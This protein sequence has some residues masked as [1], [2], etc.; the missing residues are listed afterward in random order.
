MPNDPN[1]VAWAGWH[2]PNGLATYVS[3]NTGKVMGIL[4]NNP[5]LNGLFTG[6]S[7]LAIVNMDDLLNPALIARDP[8]PSNGHKADGSVDLVGSG[9]VRFVKVQ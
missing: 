4:M 3:P 2:Q 5:Q 6:S 8:S 9:I 7:Y 1:N